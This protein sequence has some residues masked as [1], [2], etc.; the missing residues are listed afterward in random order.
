MSNA[1]QGYMARQPTETPPKFP[2]GHCEYCGKELTSRQRRWC[3]PS[4][5]HEYYLRYVATTITWNDFREGILKRDK[6]HCTE[7]NKGY[8]DLNGIGE[9]LAVHHIVPVI[10]G[11]KE[12]DEDNCI[13]LCTS[14]H[15]TR[16]QKGWMKSDKYRTQ[17][18]LEGFE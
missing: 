3:K 8:R 17:L 6:Y 10:K 4:H 13:T 18:K 5:G 2:E 7:C 9:T 11:G 15:K 16:H 14:C 1:R 12:F